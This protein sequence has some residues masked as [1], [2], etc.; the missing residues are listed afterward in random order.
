MVKPEEIH[1]LEEARKIIR[2]LQKIVARKEEMQR[3]I[4][5]LEVENRAL[6]GK[7]EKMT[8]GGKRQAAPFSR[9]EPK[10]LGQKAGH[11]TRH[12]AAPDKID[13]VLKPV[14]PEKYECGGTM[15]HN[16]YRPTAMS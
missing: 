7:F 16:L 2:A 14:L 9:G 10:K 12:R 4:N 8:R 6:K 13:R 15:A 5:R 3:R 1:D 11:E